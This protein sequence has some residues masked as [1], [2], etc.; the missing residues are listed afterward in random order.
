MKTSSSLLPLLALLA[1]FLPSALSEG[2]P[3]LE[4][5]YTTCK[6]AEESAEGD[7]PWYDVCLSS[8]TN[9]YLAWARVASSSGVEVADQSHAAVENC[10]DIEKNS[11]TPHTTNFDVSRHQCNYFFDRCL[12]GDLNN[13]LECKLGCNIL[14]AQD[15]ITGVSEKEIESTVYDAIWA[16]GVLAEFQDAVRYTSSTL[17][18]QKAWQICSWK[19]EF[20]RGLGA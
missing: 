10:K 2:G 8:C 16:A 9:S 5:L 11:G 7:P 13:C 12:Q 19:E 20:A 6:R 18:S 4:T 14:R 17:P 15:L 1:T 3:V